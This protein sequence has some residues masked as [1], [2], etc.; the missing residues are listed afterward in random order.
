MNDWKKLIVSRD[1]RI[2]DAIKTLDEGGQQ[3]VFVASEKLELAGTVS[4][5]DIRRAILRGVSLEVS[6]SEIMNEGP[7]VVEKSTPITEIKRLMK[8]NLVSKIPVV[9]SDR[10]LEGLYIESEIKNDLWKRRVAVIMCGGLGKRLGD[11]TSNCPKP[12]LNIGSK[13]ILETIVDKFVKAGCERI[14][15]SVNYKSQMIKEYFGNGEKWGIEISYLEEDKKLGTAGG[16][17]LIEE[18]IEKSIVVMNGDILTNIDFQNFITY[19]EES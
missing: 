17:S 9:N 8:E 6:V 14:Y 7:I 2:I 3:I 10:V 13:P 11:L 18:E 16:L 12:L 1:M 15:L 5:G 19:H 4:D